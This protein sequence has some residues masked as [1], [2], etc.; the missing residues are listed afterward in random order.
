LTDGKCIGKEA[1]LL[2]TVKKG[3]LT[4]DYLLPSGSI[5]MERINIIAKMKTVQGNF[6]ILQRSYNVAAENRY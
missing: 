1:E 6:Y 5:V 4:L 2:G 3:V